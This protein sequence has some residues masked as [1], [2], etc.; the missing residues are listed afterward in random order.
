MATKRATPI[1]FL[2]AGGLFALAAIR[3]AFF[4]H[5][6]AVDVGHPTSNAALAFFFMAIGAVQLKHVKGSRM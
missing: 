4:P 5:F 2:I 3:D 6:F 1:L